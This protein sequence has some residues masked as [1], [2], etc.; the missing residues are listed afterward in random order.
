MRPKSF[1]HWSDILP[2]LGATAVAY[3]I[4]GRLGLLLAIPPGY[5]TAVWPASGIALAGI[6]LF[7]Y[8]VWPGILLGSFLI[9]LRTSLDTTSTASILTT[10]A[11]AA[12]IGLGASLQAVVGAFLIRRFTQYPT[13]FVAARD[14][15][16]FLL[17]GGPVSCLVNATWAVTSLLLSGAMQPVDYL[18]HWWTW[19]VGDAIGV[20][21]FTPLILIWAGKPAAFSH[22][23]QVSLPLCLAFTLVVIFFIYTNAWEQDRIKLEFKRRTDHLAQQLEENFDNY[24]DVLH[25]VGNLYASSVPINRQQFKTFVS[26]WFSR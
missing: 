1:L 13:A 17:L 24:I 23:R 19:W 16:K 25:S 9:N 15:I 2:K 26:R 18:F 12:S 20:I 21:T 4:V 11:L 8:R 14:I 5:A 7:G 22:G 3:Y 6:L 10:T